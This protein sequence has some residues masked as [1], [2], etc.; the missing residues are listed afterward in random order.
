MGHVSGVKGRNLTILD[1]KYILIVFQ[2]GFWTKCASNLLRKMPFLIMNIFLLFS[3][4]I[5]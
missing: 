2:F 4:V 1:D 5:P 3:D